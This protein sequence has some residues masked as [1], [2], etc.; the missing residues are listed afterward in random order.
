MSGTAPL[1]LLAMPQMADPNFARSVILLCDYTADRGAFG[2]V[3]NRQMTEPAHTLIRTE[4][5]I[6]VDPELRLWIGGPVDPQTTWVLMAESQGPEDEQREISPGVLL[7]VSSALTIRLLQQ[8]PSARTRII[9]GYAG[10]APGQLES[11]IAASGWLTLDVDPTLIFSTPADQMWEA[12]LRR[13]GTDPS[14]L[15]MS[16][17]VH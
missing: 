13:L 14:Q 4:P 12:A 11:E 6:D 3:I 10:W 2:L 15:Q 5:P 8:R 1:L 9:V 16:S 7:S 17:G